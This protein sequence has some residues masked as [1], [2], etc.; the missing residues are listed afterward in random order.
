MGLKIADKYMG[1]VIG[2]CLAISG[3]VAM[4]LSGWQGW[5]IRITSGLGLFVFI[6]FLF[7]YFEAKKSEK[8]LELEQ[9]LKRLKKP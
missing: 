1:A 3:M 7:D 5:T 9:E 4:D 8:I 2:L 6:I